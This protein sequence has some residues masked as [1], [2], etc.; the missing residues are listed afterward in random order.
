[1][2]E[3]SI[4]VPVYNVENYLKKCVESILSQ[5]FTDFELLLVD[6]GS[7]DSSGEMCD[8]LKRLDERI[9]VIH[10]ENGGLSSARNAGIDVAKGKYL[11]FVDS[12]DYIDTHM[13]E[14]LYKNMVH[15]DADLSI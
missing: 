11:T 2:S 3:I 12:D 4:I 8:E 6:D 14:V 15:E 13:L 7:T 5:T 9:K 1:M 10:K